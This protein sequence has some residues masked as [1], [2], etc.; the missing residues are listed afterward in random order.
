MLTLSFLAISLGAAVLLACNL[1]VILRTAPHIYRSLDDVP[2]NG[3]GLLLGTSKYV[4]Q[5]G[6]NLHYST[7]IEAAAALYHAG[8]VKH[9]LLS[10]DNST[11]DYDEPTTMKKSLM[12]KGVP[13]SALTLDYAG[14]RTLDS[15]VRARDV[16]GQTKLT[17]V[18]EDFHN[19]RAVFISQHCGMD[20]VAFSADDVPVE[21]AL[22]VLARESLA[23]VL[24]LLDLYVFETEPKFLGK[25]VEIPL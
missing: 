1:W 18:S 5:G 19:Y 15:V 20:A 17:I 25:K 24:M 12:E 23:R 14:L 2:E 10:G 4:S 6:L 9:L 8:K 16:F 3:V 11:D 7:R 22:K 13:D 21:F